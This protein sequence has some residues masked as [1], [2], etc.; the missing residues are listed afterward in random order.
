MNQI[1]R[2]SSSDDTDWIKARKTGK[3][4]REAIGLA[5]KRVR[6]SDRNLLEDSLSEKYGLG[7][8]ARRSDRRISG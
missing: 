6:K 2:S 5:G 8:Q 4:T 1:P 7:I 3:L